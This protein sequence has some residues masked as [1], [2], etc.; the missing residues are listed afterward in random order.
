MRP[1]RLF[2]ILIFIIFLSGTI[3]SQSL[4]DTT[5][6]GAIDIMGSKLGIIVKFQT[7]SGKSTGTIDIPQQGALGLELSKI[8][9]KNPKLHFELD[10][11]NGL[12][13][14]E[15]LYYADSIGGTFLRSGI[16]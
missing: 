11:P 16:A 2:S 5:W 10:V 4:I 9:F 14:F 8:S 6:S 15:G 13:V 3:V 7:A 1:S 12:A